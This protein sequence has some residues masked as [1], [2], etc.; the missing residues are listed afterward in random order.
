MKQ[1]A[2]RTCRGRGGGG[3][4]EANLPQSEVAQG[5]GAGEIVSPEQCSSSSEERQHCADD[6]ADLLLE[7][8]LP[9]D[10]VLGLKKGKLSENDF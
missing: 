2:R 3:R 1:P 7:V 5:E 9:P 10:V 4:E 8:N 6:Q